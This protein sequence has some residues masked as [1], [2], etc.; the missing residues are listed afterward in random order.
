MANIRG[1]PYSPASP[2]APRNHHGE[3]KRLLRVQARVDLGLIG[4]REVG[5]LEV[6][7]TPDALGDI[8]S[9]ELDVHPTQR[10]SKLFVD[11]ER[12]LDLS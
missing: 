9:G 4:P 12:R 6:P 7:C 2:R 1:L 11:A 5:F 8:L 3:L 10:R